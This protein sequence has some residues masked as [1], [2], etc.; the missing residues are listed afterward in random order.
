MKII[1]YKEDKD[2][3]L[4]T[5]CSISKN[6]V[7]S[8]N[9]TECEHNKLTDC[10]SKQVVCDYNLNPEELKK[11]NGELRSTIN[12]LKSTKRDLVTNLTKKGHENRKLKSE[13]SELQEKIKDWKEQVKYLMLKS[14]TERT[15]VRLENTKLRETISS[16]KKRCLATAE[17]N[18]ILRGRYVDCTEG[19]P[20]CKSLI[21]G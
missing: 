21:G 16:L 5:R 4:E 10:K 18:D 2:G 6:M 1:K 13:V 15:S 8:W 20:I 19:C 7:G 3:Y 17:R 12:W 9:C 14:T 11:E